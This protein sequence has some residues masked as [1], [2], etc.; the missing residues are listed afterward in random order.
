MLFLGDQGPVGAKGE[1]GSDGEVSGF[2]LLMQ[3]AAMLTTSFQDGSPGIAGDPGVVGL[4]GSP[5]RRGPRGRRVNFAATVPI[6]LRKLLFILRY[7]V[8]NDIYVRVAM[9]WPDRTARRVS[10]VL[11]AT[12][13]SPVPRA[14]SG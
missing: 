7:M 14:S 6:P 10:R 2:A 11:R 5:G 9:G 1:R 4:P 13:A 3:H 8:V 12:P